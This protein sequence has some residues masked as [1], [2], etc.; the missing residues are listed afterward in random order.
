VDDEIINRKVARRRL[1]RR[2]G[3]VAAGVAGLTAVGVAVAT[4]A[5]AG[6]G[7]PM[8]SGLE[9]SGATESTTLT[10]AS[11]TKPTLV[12]GN[13]ATT[14]SVP[15][16]IAGAALQLTPA[17][18]FV[19]G[20]DGSV[21]M[22][23]DGTLW[24]RRPGAGGTVSDFVRTGR[25]STVVEAFS[26]V[27]I[28]DT[29]P[30]EPGGKVGIMNPTALDASGFIKAGAI[31]NLNLDSLLV[32]GWGILANL[33]VLSGNTGA[34]ITAWPGGEPRPLASNVNFG[35]SQTIANFAFIG[36]GSLPGADNVISIF[37]RQK[38]Q[39]IVDVAGA[40]VNFSSDVK[41]V[42]GLSAMAAGGAKVRERPAH[43]NGR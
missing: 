3:T 4:P 13:T 41:S 30:N 42:A 14:G 2:A 6:V 43:L 16:Q 21:G 18:N 20:P 25:N 31:L 8:V 28:L 12:L 36:L 29:R 32:W 34:Y 27:R 15:N 23:T 5:I 9:N 26:P 17:G 40:V 38:A 11:T 10:N 7:D 22:T 35:P 24:T 1:L 33:T 19:G 37:A 39:V